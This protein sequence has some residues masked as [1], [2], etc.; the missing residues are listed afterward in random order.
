MFDMEEGTRL[1]EEGAHGEACDSFLSAAI[2]ELIDQQY[3]PTMR[4][5]AA[6][7][8]ALL[9][10]GAAASA[11]DRSRIN[12][13]DSFVCGLTDDWVLAEYEDDHARAA[14]I[15]EWRGDAAL[16]SGRRAAVEEYERAL[17]RFSRADS[18]SADAWSMELGSDYASAALGDYF[19]E[20]AHEVERRELSA[21]D[22]ER[23]LEYKTEFAERVIE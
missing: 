4:G 19:E 6:V 11:G 8:G 22:F 15:A 23:R 7:G 3:D 20:T 18:R 14:I 1:K 13:A 12:V 21:T 2:S 10:L 9:A 16:L 5:G 17:D